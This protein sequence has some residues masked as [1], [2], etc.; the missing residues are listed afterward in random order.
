MNKLNV[1]L[2]ASLAILSSSANAGLINVS[3]ILIKSSQPTYL[4]I[5]EVVATQTGS[6]NDLALSSAGATA[7]GSGNWSS[8]STPDKAID[9]AGPLDYPHMYHSDGNSASEFL[10]ISLASASELDSLTLFGRAGCCSNR[11]IF[12]VFLYS[13]TDELLFSGQNYSAFNS[14]H[15]VTIDLPDTSTPVPEPSL[16][17]LLGLG[18]ASIGFARRRK[19]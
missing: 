18:L 11:D 13:D 2:L 8:T 5:S 16:L 9:G 10:R 12:D 15:S 14:S 6:G 4:Q 1:C 7:S 3:Q 17:A 19:A